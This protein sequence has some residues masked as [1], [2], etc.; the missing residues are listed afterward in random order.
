MA[1]KL[2]V[3]VFADFFF[4]L[5]TNTAATSDV[6]PVGRHRWTAGGQGDDATDAEPLRTDDAAR[7][8]TTINTLRMSHTLRK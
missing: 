6:G 2:A 1:T 8:P 5:G 4:Y 7:L 3:K